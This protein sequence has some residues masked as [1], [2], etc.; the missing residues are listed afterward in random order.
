M[1][2]LETPWIALQ[3]FFDAGGNVLWA[4]FVATLVMWA[5]I[6][7]RLSVFERSV[8]TNPRSARFFTTTATVVRS[9][10]ATPPSV[11]W[12]MAP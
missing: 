10:A 6:F 12:S 7:E 3:G 5:M 9:S 11:A 8:E 4:I 2:D 1:I